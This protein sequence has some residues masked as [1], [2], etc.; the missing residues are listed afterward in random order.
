MEK[1]ERK[2]RVKDPTYI[3][4]PKTLNWHIVIYLFQSNLRFEKK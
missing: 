3:T 2:T 1:G 4:V